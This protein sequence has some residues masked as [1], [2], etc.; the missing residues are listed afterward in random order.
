MREMGYVLRCSVFCDNSDNRYGP[1]I[2]FFAQFV[3]WFLINAPASPP[4]FSDI[5]QMQDQKSRCH[6][7]TV[8]VCGAHEPLT[9]LHI[10]DTHTKLY[11]QLPAADVIIHSGDF[12][13][14]GIRR[15]LQDIQDFG[16]YFASLPF[17]LKILV[18]GNHEYGCDELPYAEF[19]SLVNPTRDPNTVVLIDSGIEYK[20]VRFY[21]SPWTHSSG[22]WGIDTDKRAQRFAQIPD[23]THV[24]ITHQPPF[25]VLDLAWEKDGT[26]RP[27]GCPALREIVTRKQIPLH[28]FGHVHDDVG[29]VSVGP[30]TFS[31]AALD[32]FRRPNILHV[33]PTVG[34]SEGGK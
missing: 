12:L 6:A 15:G 10:S 29:I 27:W 23:D 30:T 33:V 4:W 32:I 8:A 22:S 11:G 9:I 21:G 17:K 18:P 19:V 20:G 5:K 26:Y 3:L 1:P 13:N 14:D 24:L 28:C 31:N 25:E 7:A 34:G 16:S 2:F